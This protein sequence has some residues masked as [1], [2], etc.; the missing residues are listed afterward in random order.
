MVFINTSQI[1]YT[2]IDSATTNITGHLFLTFFLF[3]LLV[4]GLAIAFKIPVEYT[5]IFILPLSLVLMGSMQEFLGI[6][7]AL[8][9]YLGFL[10]AKNFFFTK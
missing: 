1:I 3:F 9:L 6:G 7:G 4:I 10:L 2:V 8:L 5:A